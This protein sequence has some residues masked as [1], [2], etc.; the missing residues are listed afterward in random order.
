MKIPIN[1]DLNKDFKNDV[2]KGFDW[3]ELLYGVIGL[4]LIIVTAIVCGFYLHV[5][6]Q[7]CIVIGVVPAI[8]VFYLGFHKIQ[9]MSVMEYFKE[10]LYDKMTEELIY[11]ADEIP[12]NTNVW[13][14]EI[15]SEKEGKNAFYKKR[16][17]V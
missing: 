5:P 4:V 3:K 14:M 11:D 6:A 1:R 10:F 7:L 15:K 17:K 16:K 12:P 8:P 2:F 9:D 13:T